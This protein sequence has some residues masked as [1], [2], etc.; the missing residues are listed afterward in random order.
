MSGTTVDLTGIKVDQGI[1]S[2]QEILEGMTE[3][4]VGQNQDQGQVQIGIALG[5]SD[6]ENMIILP[7]IVQT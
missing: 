7:K 3:V 6:V 2:S 4:A 1:N 5:A